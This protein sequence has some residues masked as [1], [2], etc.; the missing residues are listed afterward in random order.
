MTQSSF[1]FHVYEK[2]TNR[3]IFHNLTVDELEDKLRS[4]DIQ[5]GCHDIEPVE[6]RGLKD[7]P[8]D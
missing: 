4:G 1:I 6:Q 3:C 7:S 5:F 2:K 8:S